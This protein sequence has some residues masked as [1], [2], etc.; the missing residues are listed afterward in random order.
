M[1]SVLGP[2]DSFIK[3]GTSRDTLQREANLK[4]EYRNYEVSMLGDMTV[5]RGYA[6]KYKI[7]NMLTTYIL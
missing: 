1:E 7:F 5:H 2:H 4:S 6:V 3:I